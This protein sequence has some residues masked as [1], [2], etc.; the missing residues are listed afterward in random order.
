MTAS[1][2]WSN[3]FRLRYATNNS[4]S[5]QIQIIDNDVALMP[6]SAVDSTGIVHIGYYKNYRY[7]SGI[8]RLAYATNK[9]GQWKTD[10]I[11]IDAGHLESASRTSTVMDSNNTVHIAYYS[12]GNFD[13]F[14]GKCLKGDLRYTT[15]KYG[16]WRIFAVDTVNDTG[17]NPAM[18]C[19]AKNIIHI[20][21]YEADNGDLKHAVINKTQQASIEIVDGSGD[22]GKF[23]SLYLDPDGHVMIAYFDVTSD[24]IKIA[25][26]LKGEWYIDDVFSVHS[27]NHKGNNLGLA[28]DLSRSLYIGFWDELNEDLV[29]TESLCNKVTDTIDANCDDTDGMDLDGDG[30]VSEDSG[31]NDCDDTKNYVYSGY[32]QDT[33][34]GVEMGIR[35]RGC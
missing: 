15:N 20:S 30:H 21:F 27:L 12:C 16:E 19:D 2:S 8:D 6:S 25:K 14:T 3:D 18:V 17:W 34:D 5:W 24:K 10:I 29:V 1:G 31:G 11:D 35:V 28:M 23:S 4:G 9:Y 32:I 13:S 26:H 33:V 7:T 22:V